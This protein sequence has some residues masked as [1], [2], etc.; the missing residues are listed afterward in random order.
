MSGG[1][2]PLRLVGYWTE[3]RIFINKQII[4]RMN[5]WFISFY[6]FEAT[7]LCRAKT[8]TFSLS[9]HKWKLMTATLPIEID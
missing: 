2:V 3:Y 6:E 4:I 7:S 5:N 1:I 8:K 9:L